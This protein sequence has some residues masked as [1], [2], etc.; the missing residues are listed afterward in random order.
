MAHFD[1][2]VPGNSLIAVTHFNLQA[3]LVARHSG[4]PRPF[5]FLLT[6]CE[7][8]RTSQWTREQQGGPFWRS[9]SRH[10]MGAARKLAMVVAR[11]ERAFVPLLQQLSRRDGH[12]APPRGVDATLL[13]SRVGRRQAGRVAYEYLPKGRPHTRA[14]LSSFSAFCSSAIRSPA[15]VLRRSLAGQAQPAYVLSNLEKK[16][17]RWRV[18]GTGG[19]T[20]RSAGRSDAMQQLPARFKVAT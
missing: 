9:G 8:H 6:T 11:S 18:G 12:L 3:I 7:R 15:R 16:K 5:F 19:V 10:P 20:P 2:T 1:D 13:S 4:P 14:R 17:Q